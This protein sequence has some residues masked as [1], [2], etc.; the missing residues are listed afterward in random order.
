MPRP[1]DWE[2]E[3]RGAAEELFRSRDPEVLLSGPAGTGKSVACLA[4]LDMCACKYPGMRAVIV[5]KTRASL[6][7]T[8][9]VTFEEGVLRLGSAVLDGPSRNMRRTYRY[10][11]GSTID[12]GGIDEPS[13]IM[14]SDY[15]LV[16]VQEATELTE[17][18]WEMLST[19]LRNGKMPYQQIFGDCNPDAPTHWLY[20][21][22][23]PPNNRCRMLE[24]RHEDNPVLYDAKAGAWTAVGIGYLAKLDNLSGPR[25]ERLRHGRWVQAEG[26]VYEGWDRTIHLI[27]RFP[28]PTDWPRYLG[29]DFGYTN[30]FVC[31]F[32]AKDNDGR[33]YLH[34]EWARCKML[35]EDHAIKI[36]QLL[37]GEPRPT[38][39]ICDHDAEDRAT[40][41]KHLGMTT[42]A[43]YKA[44]S[45]GIQFV[46]ARLK[47]QPDGKPRLM[48][49][50]DALIDRC[51][52]MAELS[53][54]CGVVEEMDSY[55][56]PKVKVTTADGKPLKEVPVDDNN[57]SMDQ[58]R[59]V[60]AELDRCSTPLGYQAIEPNKEQPA[61]WY[62]PGG[63]PI[64]SKIFKMI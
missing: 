33:L 55:I 3:I 41:E 2:L 56:W 35:V 18:D 11:N 48:V 26:V 61:R 19:R 17:N 43:A 44:I 53:K 4:R 7:T 24:S 58:L 20:K 5:R 8:G 9:L 63:Q 47:K 36:K 34:R 29:I 25:R 64:K 15:D 12:V 40:L 54:P 60:V 50:R 59:Y 37:A 13:R 45:D 32:Y 1:A 51:P 49:F 62:Q 16:Y 42:K 31:G 46:A 38:A 10:P 23:Q 27:D 30:L 21:R 22:C 57:H 39:I 14:S 52:H 28:I 6:T